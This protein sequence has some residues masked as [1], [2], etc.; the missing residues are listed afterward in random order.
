MKL[1]H[2]VVDPLSILPI[3]RNHVYRRNK[4]NFHKSKIFSLVTSDSTWNNDF[5]NPTN[6]LRKLAEKNKDG[7]LISLWAGKNY[8]KINNKTCLG[9]LNQL[10]FEFNN[11]QNKKIEEI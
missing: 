10:N 11:P 4:L 5:I 2:R 6:K 3:K 7:E 1:L 8:Q 9:I